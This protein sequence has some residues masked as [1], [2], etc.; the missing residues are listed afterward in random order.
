MNRGH[1]PS[2]SRDEAVPNEIKKLIG[3]KLLHQS[4]RFDHD[5]LHMLVYMISRA[6]QL[7]E[8]DVDDNEDRTEMSR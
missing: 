8:D 6:L 5:E 3:V 1:R 7:G 4:A 2:R